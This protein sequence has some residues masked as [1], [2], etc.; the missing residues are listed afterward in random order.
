M[1]RRTW[2][3]GSIP[4]FMDGNAP[5]SRYIQWT[6]QGTRQL[7]AARTVRGTLGQHFRI[8]VPT[9]RRFWTLV[10]AISLPLHQNHDGL[11]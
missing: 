4:S 1:S 11:I 7:P 3:R 9:Y 6:S 5:S 8:P 2:E 10:T